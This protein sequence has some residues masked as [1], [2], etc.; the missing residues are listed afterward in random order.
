MEFGKKPD[1]EKADSD[2]GLF[3]IKKV[4]GTLRVVVIWGGEFPR[5]PCR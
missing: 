3:L 4:S 2:V 1:F 5:Y